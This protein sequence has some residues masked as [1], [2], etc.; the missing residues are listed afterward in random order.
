MKKRKNSLE[1]IH[2]TFISYSKK[3]KEFTLHTSLLF[4]SIINCENLN[5]NFKINIDRWEPVCLNLNNFIRENIFQNENS[6]YDKFLLVKKIKP[7]YLGIHAL[8]KTLA[9]DMNLGENILDDDQ[10]IRIYESLT[11]EIFFKREN[12]GDFEVYK[13]GWNTLG[14]HQG[15]GYLFKISELNGDVLEFYRG[16]FFRGKKFGTKIEGEFLG[17]EE[18]G[19]YRVR[20]IVG[21]WRNDNLEKVIDNS[22]WRWDGQRG[23]ERIEE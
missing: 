17:R 4:Q 3:L 16:E 13:G 23:F 14:Q 20:V 2:K 5:L 9:R 1:K 10:H 6:L 12:N 21:E 22:I 7:P 18:V 15:F 8:E 11:V 19:N